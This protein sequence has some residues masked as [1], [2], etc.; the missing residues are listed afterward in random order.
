MKTIEKFAAW[1]IVTACLALT[2][3]SGIADAYTADSYQ[4][5]RGQDLHWKNN[6]ISTNIKEKDMKATSLTA[7]SEKQ[8]KD[9]LMQT[10]TIP[11]KRVEKAVSGEKK[12]IT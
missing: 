2:V 10:N 6:I 12:N 7:D 11:I 3:S 8:F 1:S 4:I 5:T 9:D